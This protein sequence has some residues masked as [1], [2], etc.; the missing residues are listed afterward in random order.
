MKIPVNSDEY[1]CWHEVGH[2]VVCLHLGGDVEFIEIPVGDA[3][4][5]PFARCAYA[6]GTF[7]AIA[8][9]GFAAE[10][11][12]L[13]NGLAELVGGDESVLNAVVFSNAWQDRE[14]FFGR[15]PGRGAMFTDAEDRKF[16]HHAI[17]PDGHDGVIPIIKQ[18]FSG[19]QDL[20][21]ELLVARRVEG[22]RVKELLR[23]ESPR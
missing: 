12:L 11:Y 13:K 15:K 5:H 7:K 2:A 19:M 20:V 1:K 16:M 9:G 17:G 6:P 22:K 3:R 10:F 4:S 14:D 8:C 23:V 21:R 18:H